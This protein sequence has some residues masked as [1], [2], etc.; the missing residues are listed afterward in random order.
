MAW[1]PS[2]GVFRNL[3]S[4]LKYTMFAAEKQEGQARRGRALSLIQS[5]KI[6][7]TWQ[8]E[9]IVSYLQKTYT[10]GL[11][12]EVSK[13]YSARW[14]KHITR[15]MRIND[16]PEAVKRYND[17][18]AE[19]EIIRVVN[20]NFKTG[21]IYLTLTYR[22]GGRPSPEVAAKQLKNYIKA[23]R[24]KY[25]R[26]GVTLKWIASTAYGSKGG[27]HHHLILSQIDARELQGMW[28]YGGMHIDFLYP[29]EDHSGLASYIYR[30]SKTTGRPGEVITGKRISSSRNLIRPKPV[31]KEIDAIRWREPPEPIK[32]YVIDVDS[33]EAGESP[34]S[35]APYLFYRMRKIPRG[36]KAKTPDGETLKGDAAQ[37]WLRDHNR[38]KVKRGFARQLATGETGKLEVLAAGQRKDV[39]RQ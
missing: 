10:A 22:R 4:L 11:T 38:Q 9:E 18:M 34:V 21:D 6:R 24:R 30:Q 2:A 14:G 5:I 25:K 23:V 27:I 15:G 17:K 39:M 31:V 37:R 20:A 28:K 32:G 16:T 35:G 8:T 12:V 3:I 33:I 7:T 13:T 36:Y 29:E 1:Q 26:A 19:R